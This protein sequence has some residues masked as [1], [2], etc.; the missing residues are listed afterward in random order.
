MGPRKIPLCD[1][2]EKGKTRLTEVS[3]FKVDV[4]KQTAIVE[5]NGTCFEIGSSLVYIVAP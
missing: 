3:A 5:E 4:A 1:D 2:L